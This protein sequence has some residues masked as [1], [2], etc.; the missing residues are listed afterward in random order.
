MLIWAT[1]QQSLAFSER[2]I[3]MTIEDR[4]QQIKGVRR[5]CG[6]EWM[7]ERC[8]TGKELAEMCQILY[9]RKERS[10]RDSDK[11]FWEEV[12]AE[13]VEHIAYAMEE[14]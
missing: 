5:K 2:E 4:F 1:N 8:A 3:S 13:K 9:L 11:V 6:C 12:C 14:L 10:G 7:H